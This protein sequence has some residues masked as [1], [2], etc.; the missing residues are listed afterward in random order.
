M[1]KLI[2]L[3]IVL[4]I[5]LSCKTTKK[6]AH[7]PAVDKQTNIEA[8]NQ[9]FEN[10]TKPMPVVDEPISVR[11][12][13]IKIYEEKVEKEA[14]FAYYVIIGSFSIVENA[15]KSK[16]EMINKGFVPVLLTTDSGLFR[17]AVNQSNFENEARSI[18][19]EIRSRFPE[20]KDVWLLKKK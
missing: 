3:G 7:Q 18:I 14:G 5:G 1:K 12:E 4:M 9:S 13:A 17:V 16:K 15:E 19:K 10:E 8:V 20:H 2:I 6:A 11:T